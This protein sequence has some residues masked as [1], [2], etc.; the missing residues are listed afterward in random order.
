V[1]VSGFFETGAAPMQQMLV[2]IRRLV[3]HDEG[4]DL[5]E[6]GLLAVLIAI[7][8]MGAVTTVGQTITSVFWNN[9][10]QNF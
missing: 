2:A 3:R 5:L 6:Y 1:N 9:I 7:L 4:Q 10:A 8:A